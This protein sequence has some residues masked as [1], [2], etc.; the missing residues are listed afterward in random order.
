[1]ENR[2]AWLPRAQPFVLY[3]GVDG[4]LLAAPAQY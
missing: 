1:M 4:T 3:S 2:P